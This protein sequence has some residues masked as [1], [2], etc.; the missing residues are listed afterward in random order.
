MISGFK[1]ILT[2]F[3][4]NKPFRERAVFKLE[5][6]IS[7]RRVVGKLH[8]DR[9]ATLISENYPVLEKGNKAYPGMYQRA[10]TKVMDGLTDE[11]TEEVQRTREEW[12]Q[13]GPP[14]DVRLK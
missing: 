11:E 8:A 12:Q 5:R 7:E 3:K 9:V 4:N 6:K 10:L 14:I 1:A 2:W 13:K